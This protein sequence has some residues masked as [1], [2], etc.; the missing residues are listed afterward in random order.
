MISITNKT[1]QD[2]EFNTVLHTISERCNTEIGTQK[3][4]EI[5]PFKDKE[6]LMDALVQTNK[7]IYAF[8]FKLDGSATEALQQ[9]KN[10]GYLKPYQ[11]Q[12]KE[13][14]GI[15]LNFSTATK[16]VQELLWEKING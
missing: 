1:L 4:L 7:Y 11:N 15:G 6:T 5:I 3:A 13:C 8:E 10:K 16:Q 12:Y 9:I 14:I 2:L